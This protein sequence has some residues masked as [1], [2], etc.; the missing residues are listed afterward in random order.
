MKAMCSQNVK[1]IS[2]ILG[3]M[4]EAA[5]N[6]GDTGGGF[7]PIH[8][9][10]VDDQG[11]NVLN[12]VIYCSVRT[13]FFQEKK[14]LEVLDVHVETLARWVELSIVPYGTFVDT[15]ARCNQM[16]LALKPFEDIRGKDVRPN[17]IT[18]IALLKGHAGLKL[19]KEMRLK[20]TV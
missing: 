12:S 4:V 3:C 8:E 20:T 18:Y 7:D 13:E 14:T 5:V 11:R 19:L 2:I 10:Q 15:C 16:E 6:D 17:L 1:P 9:L